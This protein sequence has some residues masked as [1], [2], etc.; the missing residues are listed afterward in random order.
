MNT[1]LTS[2]GAFS[3]SMQRTRFLIRWLTAL[4]LCGLTFS[5][6]RP[7]LNNAPSPQTL[8]QLLTTGQNLTILRAAITRAGLDAQLGQSAGTLTLFAPTDAAFQAAGYANAAAIANVPVDT[9]KRLLQYHVLPTKLLSASV[10]VGTSTA[11]PTVA[12]PPV[13]ITRTTPTTAVSGTATSGTVIAS[14]LYVNGARISQTDIQG[15]N[16]VVHVVDKLLMPPSGDLVQ[17]LGRLTAQGPNS[18]SL[19]TAAITKVGAATLLTGSGPYTLFAPTDAAF[20]KTIPT[21]RT[22]ADINVLQN[23]TLRIILLNHVVTGR[24][25]SYALINQSTLTSAVAAATNVPTTGRLLVSTGSGSVVLTSQGLLT[26]R[27]GTATVVR[28]DIVATNGVVH[29]IDGLLLP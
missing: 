21:I 17:T 16:G 10:A 14:G 19:L 15:T 23:D 18:F 26:G 25:F 29:V 7:D 20:T 27:P 24:L 3:V 13:Y 8:S 11:L 4:T 12:G 2:G 9:L 1:P 28:P 22:V 6:C 5:A